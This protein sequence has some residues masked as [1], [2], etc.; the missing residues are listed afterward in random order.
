MT[1]YQLNRTQT[2]INYTH[3]LYKGS[4]EY[5]Q[6]VYISKTLQNYINA[7][8]TEIDNHSA[9]WDKIKKITNP[10][11][12]IHTQIPNNKMSVSKY[13]PLS[14]SYFKFIELS[15]IFSLITDIESI[16]SINS[17]HLA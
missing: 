5:K 10:Y 7:A 1:Y 17:F 16:S 13:K 8:K 2:D 14:R 15:N 9:A 3:F 6:D 11:E 4:N 12:F